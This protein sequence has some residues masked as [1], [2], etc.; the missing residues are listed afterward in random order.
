[1]PEVAAAGWS[2]LLVAAINDAGQIA[3]T[4]FIGGQQRA[5]LLSPVPIPEPGTWALMLAGLGLLAA[6]RRR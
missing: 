3:G 4:G 1:L 6:R 2:S 5:F